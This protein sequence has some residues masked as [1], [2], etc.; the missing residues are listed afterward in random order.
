MRVGCPGW[1]GE[2]VGGMPEGEGG[3][4]LMIAPVGGCVDNQ[5]PE[6]NS[7]GLHGGCVFGEG[8]SE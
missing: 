5:C 2:L 1:E 7:C 8:C 3:L 6:S 4:L